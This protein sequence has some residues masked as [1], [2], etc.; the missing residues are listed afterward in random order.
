MKF[1]LKPQPVKASDGS[2]DEMHG[3]VRASGYSTYCGGCG[4]VELWVRVHWVPAMS[5]HLQLTGRYDGGSGSLVLY[6]AGN[7][8]SSTVGML[9]LAPKIH[10]TATAYPRIAQPAPRQYQ[11]ARVEIRCSEESPYRMAHTV[12]DFE[13]Q[14]AHQNRIE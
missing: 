9:A 7:S 12:P 2:A 14:I 1:Y 8:P 13:Y 6:P 4:R 5:V 11:V 3:C 10:A